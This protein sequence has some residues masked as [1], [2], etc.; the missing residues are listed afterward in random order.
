MSGVTIETTGTTFG[1]WLKQRRKDQ[2]IG[3]DD[4]A[5]RIGCSTITLLKV[6]AGER[7]PS[8]QQSNPGQLRHQSGHRGPPRFSAI[9]S[10][11]R[12]YCN[13]ESRK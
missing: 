13:S 11:A 7:R 8:R 12:C 9:L 2:G 5:E 6:E 1:A 4:F 3:P 10:P